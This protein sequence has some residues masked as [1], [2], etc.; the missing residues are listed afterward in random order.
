MVAAT[1][2]GLTDDCEGMLLPDCTGVEAPVGKGVLA[3]EGSSEVKM[4]A[5]DGEILYFSVRWER[6]ASLKPAYN[7]AQVNKM[8]SRKN[9][10][11][12]SIS[13]TFNFRPIPHNH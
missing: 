9:V 12:F 7:N 5:E 13:R 1:S 11:F 6:T 8:T 3:E 4:E 10:S 2:R